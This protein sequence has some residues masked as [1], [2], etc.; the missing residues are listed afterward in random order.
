M[1]L[2]E[3]KYFDDMEVGDKC[4]SVGRTI[5]EADIVN[6]AG[7]S[8]D[9]NI[10]HTDAEYAKNSIAGQR[11]AHGFLS[12]VVASGLYTRTPY[13]MAMTGT[14]T[15]F[16]EIRSWKFKKPVLIGDTIHVEV[17]ITE[18]IDA[19]PESSSGKIVM[20]R[21]ILNQ[22]NEIVQTGEFVLLVKKRR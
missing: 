2:L 3:Q 10:L 4:V 7:I 1:D 13:G 16:T 9:Y 6:F 11:L 12:M 20:T 17:E 14:L 18:K 21:T 5:T 8:G 19:K 22:R 15:A